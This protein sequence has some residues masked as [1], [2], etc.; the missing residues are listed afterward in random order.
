MAAGILRIPMLPG[1][2][3]ES[4]VRRR[5]RSVSSKC[6][7]IGW[8][9]ERHCKRVISW[10]DH[11]CRPANANSWP[12]MLYEHKGFIWL[13]TKRIAN[14]SNALGGRTGTRAAPGHVAPRWHDGVRYAEE[15]V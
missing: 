11:I 2:T 14:N 10:R 6:R 1:E 12:A 9:S 8:W 4:Y 3:P 13:L 15:M 5:N 7:K